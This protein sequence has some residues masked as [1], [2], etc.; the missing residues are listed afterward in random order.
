MRLAGVLIIATLEVVGLQPVRWPVGAHVGVSIDSANAPSWSQPLVTRAISVWSAA[1]APHL[2]LERASRDH[3]QIRVRFASAPGVYG[4]TRPDIDPATGL[5]RHADVVIA[6]GTAGDDPLN[7]RIVLYL[8]ALH[9]LGHAIG[10]RHTDTFA[11]IM[12]SFRRPDD[13]ERYFGAYRRQLKTA[14]AIGSAA[15]TGLS[16]DDIA[17]VRA[18]YRQQ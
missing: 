1:T 6:T 14:D 16:A 8:T 9:E 2:T 12:Y 7:Q 15:A 4:E 5:I 10:L 17:A 3:A 13:G 11:D 18:L